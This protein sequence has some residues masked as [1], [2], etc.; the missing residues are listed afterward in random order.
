LTTSEMERERGLLAAIIES[1]NDA[2]L[3]WDLEGRIV[4][5]NPAAQQIFGYAAAE[6]LGR[7]VSFFIPWNDQAEDREIMNRIVA[8]ERVEHYRA[9][10]IRKDGK[11]LEI[12][13]TASPVR[14]SA[15]RIVGASAIARD[16]SEQ[17]RFEETLARQSEELKRSNSE[18]EC[19]AHVASHDLQEP[20]RTIISYVQL[21][22][23][24]YRGRFDED[25]DEFISY[26]LD[27]ANRMRQLIQDLLA[28]SRV[29]TSGAL[30]QRVSLEEVLRDVTR[31]L[32]AALEPS[33]AVVT[34]DDLPDIM[35]DEV[36][37]HQL[38]QNLLS[39]AV[40]FHSSEPPRIH[41]QARPAEGFWRISVRDNGI[42]IS[43]RF[44]DRIFVIFQRLHVRAQYG[45]TGIGLAICKKIVE[46]H[47]GRI[48]VE[49]TPGEGS[50]FHFT[51]A[52]V[53]ESSA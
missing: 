52:K 15:G 41:L 23:G 22:A 21:L 32:E 44:F 38:L 29:Q 36:L 11:V 12:S 16:I 39:N 50:T 10:R 27:G 2:I 17:V 13:L 45:G 26:I 34:H 14:D 43:P 51:L 47:G 20:L 37:L 49:S 9:S 48:W 6:A 5:W 30:R 40:K 1:S 4:T 19:Y 46:A 18:L 25:A 33:G 53:P 7:P 24:R 3:S 28:Y 31:D 8:G 42:G 35:G